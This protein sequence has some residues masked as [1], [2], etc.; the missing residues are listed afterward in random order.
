M[1]QKMIAFELGISINTSAT[2]RRTRTRSS[3][4]T[5]PRRRCTRTGTRTRG[6]DPWSISGPEFDVVPKLQVAD[7]ATAQRFKGVVQGT[8]GHLDEIGAAEPV[9]AASDLEL[10]ALGGEPETR[11]CG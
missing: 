2:S 8:F 5:A 10:R 6:A 11:L 7:D 4:S 3:A 9:R 1:T